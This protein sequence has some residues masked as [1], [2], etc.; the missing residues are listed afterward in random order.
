ML[1]EQVGRSDLAVPGGAR[2]GRVGGRAV[3]QGHVCF[4]LVGVSAGGRLPAGFLGGGVE[5]VGEVF[6]VGV[7]DFPLGGEAGVG[8][9]GLRGEGIQKVVDGEAGG[10]GEGGGCTHHCLG[11]GSR[12]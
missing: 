6:G 7:P 5:V 12:W 11:V 4:D 8:G 1:D 2:G 10:E 9:G 3:V